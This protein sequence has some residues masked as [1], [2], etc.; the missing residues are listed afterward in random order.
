[1]NSVTIGYHPSASRVFALAIFRDLRARGVDGTLV[2]NGTDDEALAFAAAA[3][4][5]L[6]IVTPASLG[7]LH[8]HSR[9]ARQLAQALALGQPVLGLYAYGVNPAHKALNVLP[10]AMSAALRSNAV[11]TP[12]AFE[13][14]A[15][16]DS[17]D[18]LHGQLIALFENSETGRAAAPGI[19]R[20]Q[21]QSR[22]ALRLPPPGRDALLADAWLNRALTTSDPA[23]KLQALD[24][25]LQLAPERADA[26]LE[27]AV[28][29][30][31]G[32]DPVG[33]VEDFDAAATEDHDPR[34]YVLRGQARRQ[35]GDAEGAAGD[36]GVALQRDPTLAAAWSG[37]G[38]CRR[39]LGDLAG[40][41]EDFD[42]ALR[43]TKP[44][45]PLFIN[46]GLTRR[47]LAQQLPSG[48]ANAL[49]E[50]ARADY[51]AALALD[52]HSA[53]ALNNRG[54]V[55]L[56]LGDVTGA[57][58]D[59]DAALERAPEYTSARRN[60][61]AAEDALRSA[62][63]AEARSA[64]ET[65][66]SLALALAHG[67]L[68]DSALSEL[69]EALELD[70]ASA[71]AFHTRARL[72]A[73][74]GD[75][76]GAFA[77]FEHA[78]E[79]DPANALTYADRAEVYMAGGQWDRAARDFTRAIRAAPGNAHFLLRRGIVRAETA[80]YER[81]IEDFD[82]SLER[83][84][85]QAAAFYHRGIAHAALNQFHAAIADYNAALRLQP[86]MAEAYLNRGLAHAALR[87]P[88]ETRAA[89]EDLQLYMV[90]S[91]GDDRAEVELILRAL[92]KQR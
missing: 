62:A 77:D 2:L 28:L 13:P 29:R 45:A 35:S 49:L 69:G 86:D 17:L 15:F 52:P 63:T 1:M 81:A 50:A 58:A 37:R 47:A 61:S 23:R 92:Q 26:R 25:T 87:Q 9:L 21:E 16:A 70:P 74:L 24:K 57:I 11:V 56:Q 78:I 38:L 84:D 20:L 71:N 7:A 32:G 73:A 76:D 19:A 60:R 42:A 5:F 55:R 30:L 8:D 51:D 18:H 41:I 34:F 67:G 89:I 80:D 40:A 79:I 36:F 88:A 3:D 39:A 48:Q 82:A 53:I 54:V 4:V 91:S 33:A 72:R 85:A 10:Q 59:L 31:H 27:R 83:D 66:I 75:R 6:C 12:P 90:Q 14:D 44:S 22:H 68:M 46:R 64:A 65:R 43:H